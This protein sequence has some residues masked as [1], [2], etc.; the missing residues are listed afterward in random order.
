[1]RL[2]KKYSEREKRLR[3]VERLRCREG[4]RKK[5]RKKE[6]ESKKN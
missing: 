4:E 5:V 1:V 2:R 3:E 6:R